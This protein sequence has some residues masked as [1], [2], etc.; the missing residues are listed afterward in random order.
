M[1]G[2][3]FVLCLDPVLRQIQS[4]LPSPQHSLSAFADDVA[5]FSQ[6][7]HRALPVL[8]RIL[9]RASLVTGLVMNLA[10]CVIVF[11]WQEIDREEEL[12]R[13]QDQGIRAR[14]FAIQN[15]G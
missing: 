11:D 2:S 8:M 14:K 7:L 12:R 15:W 6:D 5:F 4:R 1:S 10:K 13:F 9:M 3:I